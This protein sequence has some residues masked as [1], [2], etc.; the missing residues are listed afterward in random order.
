V[1]LEPQRA[2]EIVEGRVHDLDV[3][4][5]VADLEQGPED[6]AVDLEPRRGFGGRGRVRPDVETGRPEG[7]DRVVEVRDHVGTVRGCVGVSDLVA[8]AVEVDVRRE[9]RGADSGGDVEVRD[10]GSVFVRVL[11]VAG[12]FE[13]EGSVHCFFL[14]CLRSRTVPYRPV[15]CNTYRASP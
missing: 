13:G 4:A 5:L 6:E 11:E 1:G 15:S 3:P 12:D 14:V 7:P 8:D 2:L 10:L 9:R